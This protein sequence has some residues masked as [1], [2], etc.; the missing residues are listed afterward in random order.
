MEF[1]TCCYEIDVS[2]DWVFLLLGRRNGLVGC[3]ICTTEGKSD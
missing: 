3:F 2:L 1:L